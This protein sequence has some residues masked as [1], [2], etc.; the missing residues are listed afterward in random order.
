MAN[1]NQEININN[2]NNWNLIYNKAFIADVIAQNGKTKY[3]PIPK[4][5]IFNSTNSEYINVEITTTYKQDTWDFGGNISPVTSIQTS[6]NI[7]EISLTNNYLYLGIG[8]LI[9]LQKIE[10]AN[11]RFNYYP[12]EWFRDVNIK[13]Y[14]YIGGIEDNYIDLLN[15]T[16]DLINLLL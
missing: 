7:N 12:P 2:P 9:Q 4:I 6:G 14:E 8:N 13:I 1:Y 11:Y 3:L 15:Q 5:E 10:N 16:I